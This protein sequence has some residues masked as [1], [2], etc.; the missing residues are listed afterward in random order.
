LHRA[1]VLAVLNRLKKIV[2]FGGFRALHAAQPIAGLRSIGKGANR[3]ILDCLFC[4]IGGINGLSAAAGVAGAG[5]LPGPPAGAPS[6]L[7]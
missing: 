7:V 2:G 4:P 6:G 1:A 5:S 3:T